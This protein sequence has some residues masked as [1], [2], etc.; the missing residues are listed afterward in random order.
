MSNRAV[1]GVLAALAVAFAFGDTP[2]SAQEI[3]GAKFTHQL[4]PPELCQPNRR[5]RICSWVL[6]EAQGNAG[7]E[8]APRDGTIAKIRLVACNPGG[9][10]PG[11]TFVLQIV[12]VTATGNARAIR[13]GPVINYLGTRRNCTASNNFNIE[14]FDVNVPVS[15]G[16]SLAVY[17]TQIRFMY[18]PGSGP[19]ALFDLPLADG[20][21]ARPPFTSSGFL[22]LQAELAP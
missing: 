20:E 18:N 2:A 15:K 9:R 11:G 1:L 7:K 13:S 16:D 17:A 8:K 14:E 21:A 4:T 6:E 19:S 5:H 22:M 3:F 10:P 12:R